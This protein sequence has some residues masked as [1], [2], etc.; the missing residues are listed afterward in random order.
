ML[1][2]SVITAAVIEPIQVDAT[3]RMH[4][5]LSGTDTSEDA[6]LTEYVSAATEY[7]ER[8]IGY[9]LMTQVVE[10]KLTKQPTNPQD[11]TGSINDIIT[12]TIDDGADIDGASLSVE[13][14]GILS[15][16]RYSSFASGTLFKFKC[17]AGYTVNNIPHDVKQACRLLVMHMYEIRESHKV[18]APDTVTDILDR[19]LLY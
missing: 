1:P 9:P 13:K 17:N 6:L 10:L 5:R 8:Y 16:V 11:L 2:Y 19:H 14:Y 15:Q 3:L 12:Y 7:V 4:M 18:S